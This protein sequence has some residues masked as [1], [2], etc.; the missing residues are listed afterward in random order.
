MIARIRRATP[1][2]E[3][4]FTLI[5][6]LIVIVI[7]GVLAAIAIPTLLNQKKKG[8]QASEQSDLHTVANELDTFFVDH[9][10][11]Q[12]ALAGPADTGTLSS[13]D[14]IGSDAVRLSPGSTVAVLATS[15]YGYC[16]QSTN[17][18]TGG[19]HVYYDNQHGGVL[20]G[21]A[22]CDAAGYHP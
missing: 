8:Y 21:G 1:P 10:T 4:G 20:T 22:T 2:D 7:I 9:G 16:L 19:V 18:N 14:T 13:G 6:L 17:T 5:E 12:G 15:T 3:R 11:Y